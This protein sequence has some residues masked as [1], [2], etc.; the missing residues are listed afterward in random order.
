MEPA[1]PGAC[2]LE[3]RIVYE[4]PLGPL[5]RWLGGGFVRSRLDRMFEYRHRVTVEALA[6]RQDARRLR[7]SGLR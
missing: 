1:W 3:D 7:V 4:L 5:G 6:G 2:W